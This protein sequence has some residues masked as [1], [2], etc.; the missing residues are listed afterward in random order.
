MSHLTKRAKLEQ[1]DALS[2]ERDL[3]QRFFWDA[4][5]HTTPSAHASCSTKDH[6]RFFATVY[7]TNRA[8]GGYIV[9]KSLPSGTP[10][11]AYYE[12]WTARVAAMSFD[13]EFALAMKSLAELL[14]HKLYV[15]PRE[16]FAP[17]GA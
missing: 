11:I 10:S 17:R 7:A 3:L 4:C 14:R 16:E 13:G 5:E 12:D 1:F 9:I 8:D 2:R 6:D 15:K